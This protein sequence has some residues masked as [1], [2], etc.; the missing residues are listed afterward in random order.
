MNAARQGV[1]HVLPALGLLPRDVSTDSVSGLV[2]AALGFA[3]TALG[4]AERVDLWGLANPVRAYD[5]YQLGGVQLRGIRPWRLGRVGRHDLRYQLAVG[6]AAAAAARCSI[7]HA[8]ALPTLL[9]LPNAERRVLHLHMALG[10]AT[11][12]ERHLLQRADAVVC[13]SE[14]LAAGFQQRH[15][16]YPGPVRVIRNGAD[17]NRYADASA[18]VRL[19]QHC[20]L[21]PADRV[22]AFAGQ[23][24]PEKG[25]HCLIAA[26]ELLP[27][28][29]RPHLLIAGSSSLWRSV[30]TAG[31]EAMTPFE[32]EL[33]RRCAG[34]PV[35]W[36]GKLSVGAMPGLLL[37]ADI[38]CC[39]SVALEG[40][41]TIN[42]EAAAAGK[43]VI[44]SRVGGIP[45]IVADGVGGI[46]VPPGDISALARALCRLRND[47]SLCR[48][49]GAAARR[50]VRTWAA[51][52]RELRTVYE[53]LLDGA[54]WR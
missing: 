13:A 39:P 25:I 27:P 35:H 42:L 41:A 23:V 50:N 16:Q 43:P 29:E 51:A 2:G 7:L 53:Q 21:E 20:G 15:P 6:L 31:T 54:A 3:E 1:R 47:A 9:L 22:V 32:E 52:G 44:A 4:W 45:E 10:Q 37:A 14:F 40:L 33:R 34:L 19:R 38:V 36:L 46:L 30:A 12:L 28:A 8:H 5:R 11:R 18:G 49:M 26:L 17:P 24:A 48:Q